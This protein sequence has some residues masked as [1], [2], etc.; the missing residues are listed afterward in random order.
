MCCMRVL[1]FDDLFSDPPPAVNF[2]AVQSFNEIVISWTG[3]P[4]EPCPV[5]TY[6]ITIN[7]SP[8]TVAGNDSPYTHPIIDEC[9]PTVNISI[10]ATSAA[11]PGETAATDLTIDVAREYCSIRGHSQLPT[12]FLNKTF[13]FCSWLPPHHNKTAIHTI[14]IMVKHFSSLNRRILLHS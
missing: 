14:Y 2:M 8:V 11:G 13:S 6:T 5:T 12:Y 4:D 7:G 10:F 1:L 9:G 3:E